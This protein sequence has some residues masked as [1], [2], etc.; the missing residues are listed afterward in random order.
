MED[1]FADTM[2]HLNTMKPKFSDA[3]LQLSFD[4]V[5]MTN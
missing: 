5:N 1:L 4:M 2:A 3:E